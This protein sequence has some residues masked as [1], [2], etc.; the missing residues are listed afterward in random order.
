MGTKTGKWSQHIGQGPVQG[1]AEY[2]EDD[3]SFYWPSRVLLSHQNRCVSQNNFLSSARSDFAAAENSS[4]LSY[5]AV[6]PFNTFH[7]PVTPV[8]LSS[9]KTERA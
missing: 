9:L 7:Y 6:H 4:C 3:R 2:T 5:F 1:A 8:H